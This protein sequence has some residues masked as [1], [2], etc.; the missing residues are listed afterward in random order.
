MGE[1]HVDEAGATPGPD[2]ATRA[3][4][5][6]ADEATAAGGR[7]TAWIAW[8]LVVALA[9]ATALALVQWRQLAAPAEAV[10][11]AQAAAV[12]YVRTLSTW[13]AGVGLE[14][15]YA[16]LVAGATDEFVPE[17]DDV[18]GDEQRESLVAVDA[19]S[20]GTVEDV[21]TGRLVEGD[22]P[23]VQVVV[24]VEQFVV[25]GPSADPL[26]R[27][28]RVALLRMARIGGEWLVDDLEMLSELQ[29]AEEAP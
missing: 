3:E 24:I 25:T 7:T 13:D 18:F 15:T 12:D 23:T 14:D 10:E 22:S 9:V 6:P 19:V 17:V 20:T 21:L 26:A 1:V 2:D 8:T 4:D 27:T 5:A 16:S 28:E 11:A 29:I